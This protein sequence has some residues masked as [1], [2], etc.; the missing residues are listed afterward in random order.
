[1]AKRGALKRR[2]AGIIARAFLAA[3]AVLPLPACRVLGR[4][5]GYLTYALVPRV[6]RIGMDNL[7]LAYGDA[8]DRREKK[9]ILRDAAINTTTVAAELS[10]LAKLSTDQVRQRVRLDG[11]EW[12]EAHPGS[13]LLSAHLGNWEWMAPAVAAHGF[14]VAEVVRP[15]DDPALNR[16]VD[17]LRRRH[18]VETIDKDA[19]GQR[20]FQLLRAGTSVGILVDQS[21]RDG[22][23]PATFF[24]APC[25]ATVAPAMLALRSKAPILFLF[26]TRDSDGDYTLHVNPPLDFERSGNLLTDLQTVTQACQDQVEAFVRNYPGHWLWLHRRWKPRP[27]LE[28]EWHARLARQKAKPENT[29]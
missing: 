26:M 12:L 24:G 4:W 22:G 7:D 6:R 17:A 11:R 21:P 5:L 23:V 19:A 14:P 13:V 20:I 8:I 28:T 10:H 25:W 16:A 15:L 9:R 3:T 18:D 27:K 1:M 2:I 29:E